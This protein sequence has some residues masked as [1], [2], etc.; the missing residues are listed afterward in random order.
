L[1][2]I[3][4]GGMPGSNS[5]IEMRQIARCFASYFSSWVTNPTNDGRRASPSPNDAMANQGAGAV[6]RSEGR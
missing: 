4:S 1:E 6:R 3:C 5:R 2:K